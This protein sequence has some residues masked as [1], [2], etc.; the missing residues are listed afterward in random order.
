MSPLSHPLNLAQR[1][2]M[3]DILFFTLAVLAI[4][5]ALGM[6]SFLQPMYSAISFVICL[7][8]LAGIY[9]L[10]GSSFLFAVQIIIYAGAIVSLILFI[11]MFLNIK[12][13]NLPKEPKKN[14]YLLVSSISVL[15]FSY[16][17]IYVL[18][19]LP[20][21]KEL[22][23]HFGEIKNVGLSL[24]NDFLLPF[25]AISMLLLISLI[26]AIVLAQKEEGKKGVCDDL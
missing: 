15:P 5:G 21:P 25:E 18:E 10:L 14:S 3:S 2:K 11:I 12:P 17:L 24:F 26:G 19:F 20:E 23:E 13:E 1:E 9:A 7:I 4:A 22:P 6:V 16:L 8:A